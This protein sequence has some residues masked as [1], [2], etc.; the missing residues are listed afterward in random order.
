ML[1]HGTAA[2]AAFRE[3]AV[4]AAASGSGCE[5]EAESVWQG[6]G[7]NSKRRLS[8]SIHSRP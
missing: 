6:S 4:P 8:S 3:V 7:G 5:R 1:S 2:A